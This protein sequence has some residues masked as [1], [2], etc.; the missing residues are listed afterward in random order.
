MTPEPEE[1]DLRSATAVESMEMLLNIWMT[2]AV[3][4]DVFRLLTLFPWV[5]AVTED[6]E[7]EGA[8]AV[9][10]LDTRLGTDVE[11]LETLCSSGEAVVEELVTELVSPRLLLL[12]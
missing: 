1:D 7:G 2:S 10:V 8:A 11:T 5:A 9:G 6:E 3:D 12:F 4:S